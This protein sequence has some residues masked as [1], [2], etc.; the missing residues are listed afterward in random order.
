MSK[1]EMTTEEFEQ[2][3][4]VERI[5]A[6]L[7]HE[8]E[9]G[10]EDLQYFNR[11]NIVFKLMYE[12]SREGVIRRKVNAILGPGDHSQLMADCNRIYGDFFTINPAAMRVIQEA[13]HERVYREAFQA[14]EYRVAVRALSS[15]DKLNLLHDP[16]D[17]PPLSSR[18]LPEVRLTSDPEALR[19]VFKLRDEKSS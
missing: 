11:I 12:E 16:E 10:P 8:F 14:K 18:R 4:Q 7:E 13:R 1:E 3:S 2:L 9:L 5:I 17:K 19:N 15:I 6:H